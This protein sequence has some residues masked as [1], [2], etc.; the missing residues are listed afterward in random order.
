MTM[1][2]TQPRTEQVL[3]WGQEVTMTWSAVC[4]VVLTE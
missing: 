3:T 2:N 4:G 1:A